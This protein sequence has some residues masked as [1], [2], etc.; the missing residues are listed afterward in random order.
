MHAHGKKTCKCVLLISD[1]E[2]PEQLG[3]I[4]RTTKCGQCRIMEILFGA[5]PGHVDRIVTMYTCGKLNLVQTKYMHSVPEV[6]AKQ[7]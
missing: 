4:C 2:K 5:K 1:H 3:A 6:W 7:K